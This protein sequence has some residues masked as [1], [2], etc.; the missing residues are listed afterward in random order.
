VIEHQFV[1]CVAPS[2]PVIFP[3]AT[4]HGSEKATVTEVINVLSPM[5]IFAAR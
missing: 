5:V 4:L 3:L 1:N 2:A